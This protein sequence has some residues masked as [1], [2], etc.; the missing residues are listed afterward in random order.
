MAGQ[1]FGHF[2][3]CSGIGRG[4]GLRIQIMIERNKMCFGKIVF[5]LGNHCRRITPDT[6]LPVSPHLRKHCLKRRYPLSVI[7]EEQQ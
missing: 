7:L 6:H 3:A 4:T 1:K 2:E 5:A